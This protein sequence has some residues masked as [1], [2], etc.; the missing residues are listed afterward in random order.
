MDVCI[1][2]NTSKIKAR[3]ISDKNPTFMEKG[4]IYDVYI[5]NDDTKGKFFAFYLDD[6]DEPGEY[7]LPASYFEVLK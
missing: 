2:M 7:A 5:P 4:K 3:Y 6:I 1:E